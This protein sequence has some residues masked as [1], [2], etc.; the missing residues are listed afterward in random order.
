MTFGEFVEQIN[1]V[2]QGN[3]RDFGSRPMMVSEGDE[4]CDLE[5]ID[6]GDGKV[7]MRGVRKDVNNYFARILEQLVIMNRL[8]E[9]EIKSKEAGN[10]GNLNALHRIMEGI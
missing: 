9:F 2:Y 3:E 10:Y 6:F 7:V 5:Q 8:K 1:E 4:A